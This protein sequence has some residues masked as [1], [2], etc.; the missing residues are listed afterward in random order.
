M[1]DHSVS[2]SYYSEGGED[3]ME[4]HGEVLES[5]SLSENQTP[6]HSSDSEE[7][8][9]DSDAIARIVDQDQ[10]QLNVLLKEYQE[11][12]DQIQN[13]LA[14]VVAKVR[15]S[16]KDPSSVTNPIETEGGM[17]YLEM[18]YQLMLQYCQFL[19]VYLLLKLEGKSVVGHPV[20]HRLVKLK[21][22]LE[23]LRPM[24]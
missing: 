3:S 4:F 17:S 12:L 21:L 14:P 7:L 6:P 23:K 8:Q 15:A 2:E 10:P 19:S 9:L 18:K 16:A 11:T 1:K 13:K 20:I 24:D 22:L 5:E